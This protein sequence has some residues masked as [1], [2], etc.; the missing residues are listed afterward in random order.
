[1]ATGEIVTTRVATA[2]DLPLL[3]RQE[4]A[5]MRQIEPESVDNWIAA[6]DRNLQMWADNLRHSRV[7]EVDGTAA[8]IALWM[9]T[10]EGAVL[11]TIHVLD[12]FRRRGLGRILLDAFRAGARY[13]GARV[14]TLGVH[15]DNP[16]ESLYLGA[17]FARTGVDG[18]Y[19]LYED[20]AMNAEVAPAPSTNALPL[21]AGRFFTDPDFDFDARFAVSKASQGISDLGTVTATLS[22]ITDGDPDSWYRE[23]VAT[24]DR[25]Q[26]QGEASKAAGLEESAAWFFLGASDSYVRALSFVAGMT[27]DSVEPETFRKHRASWDDFVAASRGRHLPVEIPYE[28]TTLPGYLFRPDASGAKRPTLVITNGSDGS[29]SGLW[30]EG[31][32]AGLDRSW[33]VFVF[34]GPGQQSMLFER[35]VPFRHDWE[36]VLTPVVDAL[37][38]R[39]D[40]DGDRLLASGISQGGYWLPRALAF[41]HRFVAA[42]ADGGVVDVSRAWYSN[43]PPEMLDLLHSGDKATFDKYMTQGPADPVQDRIL[44]FRARPF[45]HYDS[46]FDLFTEVG[47]Y[48]LGDV[49]SSITTP[50]LICDPDDEEFFAGQPQELFAGLTGEKELARFT[51]EEGANHHCEPW[52]RTLVEMRMCDFFQKHLEQVGA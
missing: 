25:L 31:I 41:E 19:V 28:G 17:G 21:G 50:I 11:V 52:A 26:S 23:W 42:C 3:Y 9:P 12:E 29:L 16:A 5:Y 1:M 20:R 51:R 39:D 49:V 48:Q 18:D 46:A 35:G 36:N 38:A 27:D 37:V 6:T 40:V 24:A 8:G 32:K 10:E 14:L 43:L 33:N 44:E 30:G 13:E 2:T 45:G 22:R 7:A 15:R 4:L 47:R 34:D